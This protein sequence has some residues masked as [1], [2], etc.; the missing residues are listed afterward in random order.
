MANDYLSMLVKKNLRYALIS[1]EKATWK[2]CWFVDY[3]LDILIRYN[4]WKLPFSVRLSPIEALFC[5]NES[6]P[7]EDK[8][9]IPIEKAPAKSLTQLQIRRSH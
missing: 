5:A 2:H 1:L 3:E 9:L 6:P 4:L 8:K 7:I